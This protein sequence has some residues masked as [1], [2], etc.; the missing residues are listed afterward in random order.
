MKKNKKLVFLQLNEINFDLVFQYCKKYN[1]KNLNYLKNLKN[2]KTVSEE[3]YELLE[4]WIQWLSAFTGKS[5]EDHKIFRLGDVNNNSK[6]SFIFE[7]LEKNNVKVGCIA[8]M[9]TVNNLKEPA[10]FISDPWTKT[11][12][13]NS[14]WSTKISN[15]ISLLVNNNSSGKI[16][17]KDLIWLLIVCIK[18][19]R[20]KNYYF[21]TKIFINS[22]KKRWYRALLLDFLLNEIHV[23]YY[24][25][26][27]PDFSSIF[28]NAGAHIQ[29]HYL[30]FSE[31]N[32]SNI[33][34]DMS[35]Y[36][37]RKYDPLL[38]LM[39]VYDRILNDYVKI[40]SNLIIATGLSQKALN[41]IIFYYRLKNHKDFL[42]LL[43][44][45]YQSVLPRMSR[46]FL[47][48]FDNENDAKVAEYVF[49]NATDLS[50][51]ITIFDEVDN[52]GKSLFISLTYNKKINED[53]EIYINKK[54]IKI[55]NYVNFV[56]IKNGLHSGDG[57]IFIK[58]DINTLIDTKTINVKEI[59]NILDNYY[60]N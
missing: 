20:F 28:F 32:K 58:G 57:E 29:H 55:Y 8:P 37:N 5:A 27:K 33:D 23:N 52:R 9:N 48:N 25:K 17:I 14:F 42:N 4:P 2:I 22:L 10:Y 35:W 7:K 46:D 39:K 54:N 47:V 50:K 26:Y 49:K 44:I 45:K 13:D 60:N 41:N 15:L 36:V 56:A 1:F 12:S 6:I 43:G 11:K 21:I 3:K 34:E 30:F 31:F 19:T 16:N 18:F 59:Y 38:D 24:F 53:M 40:N 51:N